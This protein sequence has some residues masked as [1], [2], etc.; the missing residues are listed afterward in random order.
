MKKTNKRFTA[1][2]LVLLL[3]PAISLFAVDFGLLLDQTVAYD[4]GVFSTGIAVPWFSALLSDTADLHVS[5]GFTKEYRDNEWTFIPELLRTELRFQWNRSDLTM[6]RMVYTDPLA[7][8][9]HGLFDG[10]RMGVDL[11]SSSLWIGAW[12][13]GLLYKDSAKITMTNSDMEAFLRKLD[14]SDFAN[15]YFASRRLITAVDWEHPGV[16]E[17]FRLRL[18]FI[19]QFD[20]NN[21]DN[22][23]LHSQYLMTRFGIP[24]QNFV[25]DLGACVSLIQYDGNNQI[26]FAGLAGIGFPTPAPFHDRLSLS[27][28]F[29][30][31]TVGDNIVAFVPITKIPQGNILEAKLSGI[32][33]LRLD[34][35]VRLHETFS[36]SIFNSYFILNDKG[37]FTGLSSGV[38]E[39]FFL[40]NEFWCQAIWSPFSDLQLRLGGG[41]FL[42]AL[43]N[44]DPSASN[45][46]KV[47]LNAVFALF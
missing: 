32:T 14:F 13:T 11:G 45:H 27:W 6:G 47:E 35:T 30:G 29:A 46:W 36:L 33:M 17:L 2:L 20:L 5:A 7:F 34:Y 42:P 22:G 40:G 31:G 15:T 16:A 44:A 28:R 3:L 18:A 21:T 43:G 23:G 8:V 24:I 26:S 12:Y 10:A 1:F 19:C 4:D 37:T 9:A 39:G 25:I 41:V 38:A